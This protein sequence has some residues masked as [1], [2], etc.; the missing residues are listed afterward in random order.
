MK[1]LQIFEKTQYIM[2]NERLRSPDRN[3]RE[4]IFFHRALNQ[5]KSKEVYLNILLKGRIVH[6]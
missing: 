6:L 4:T 1:P 5:D 2:T 3:D